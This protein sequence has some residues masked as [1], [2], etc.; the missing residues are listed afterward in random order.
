[1]YAM[2]GEINEGKKKSK[3]K[4][5]AVKHGHTHRHMK[6][7]SWLNLVADFTHNVTDGIAG[8]SFH[9]GRRLLQKCLLISLNC[10]WS[11]ICL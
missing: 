2:G 10:S 6:S 9:I 11:D 8:K 4:G 3:L 5:H 7:G 1:M